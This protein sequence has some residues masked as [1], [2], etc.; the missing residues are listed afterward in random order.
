MNRTGFG[1]YEVALKRTGC[2]AR[3]HQVF[4][5][6]SLCLYTRMQPCLPLVNGFIDDALRNTVPSVNEPLLQIVSVAFRFL[7][8]VRYSS[9]EASLR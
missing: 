4:E 2:V 3:S 1:V 5:V 7:G 6:T 9:V 8:N